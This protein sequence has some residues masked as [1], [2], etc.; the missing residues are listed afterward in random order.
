MADDEKNVTEQQEPEIQ[1][2]DP[3]SASGKVYHTD[4]GEEP[5]FVGPGEDAPDDGKDEPKKMTVAKRIE[6]LETALL[7][8]TGI[9]IED[10][11]VS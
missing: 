7:R 3:Q 6:R 1:M 10:F 9:N 11:P 2:P 5:V 4:P 8:A